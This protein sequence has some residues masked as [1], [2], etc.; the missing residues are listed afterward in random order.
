MIT[1]GDSGADEAIE[2]LRAFTVDLETE[3]S[4]HL[5]ESESEGKVPNLGRGAQ[6]EERGVSNI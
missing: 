4:K 3:L 2:S 6:E 1:T 5:G